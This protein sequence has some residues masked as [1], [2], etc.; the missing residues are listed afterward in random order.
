MC[1]I[2]DFI[3][4]AIQFPVAFSRTVAK[5][6]SVIRDLLLLFVFFIKKNTVERG[7][8]DL[9][10]AKYFCT[11]LFLDLTKHKSI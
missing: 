8:I 10:N 2:Y 4:L 11:L 1:L 7:Y 3:N 9:K 5:F 6:P